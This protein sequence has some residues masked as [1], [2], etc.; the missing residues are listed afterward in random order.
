MVDTRSRRYEATARGMFWSGIA[1]LLLGLAALAAA[2]TGGAPS[3]VCDP[4]CRPTKS[5]VWESART[6]GAV[7]AGLGASLWAAAVLMVTLRRPSPPS[8]SSRG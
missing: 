8:R 5:A 2:R 6:L 1:L 7:A 3:W 4:G